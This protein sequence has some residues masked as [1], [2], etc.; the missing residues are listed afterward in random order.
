[1]I[2]KIQ[3]RTQPFTQIDNQ[4]IRDNRLS[5]KARGLLCYLLSHVDGWNFNA[6]A[7]AKES[8]NKARAIRSAMKELREFGYAEIKYIRS[9]DGRNIQG[10]SVTIREIAKT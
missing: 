3:R 9:A 2:I 1:M 4:A 10:S 5:F 6:E 7:I 8:P